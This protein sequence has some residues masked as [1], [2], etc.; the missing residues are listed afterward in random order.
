MEC[1]LNWFKWL[2]TE[3]VSSSTPH[4][5]PSPSFLCRFPCWGRVIFDQRPVCSKDVDSESRERESDGRRKWENMHPPCDFPTPSPFKNVT[6]WLIRQNLQWLPSPQ[7]LT[8]SILDGQMGWSQPLYNSCFY[9]SGN[10]YVKYW[11]EQ[12]RQRQ[13]TRR[14][15]RHTINLADIETQC[16]AVY[17]P[18]E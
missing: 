13:R 8:G 4:P 10:Y 12:E 1:I 16:I 2:K 11:Y 9:L 18:P 7:Q 6:V 14:V 15:I 17:F 3:T 5:I